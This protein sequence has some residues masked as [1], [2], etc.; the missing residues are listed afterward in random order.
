MGERLKLFSHNV[1][2]LSINGA[3]SGLCEE[4]KAC[5]V[6]TR[7]PVLAGQ[8]DPL[9]E[10]ASLLTQTPAPST[11]DPAQEDL[12]QKYQEQVERLSQQNR[13]IKICSDAGFPTTGGC[14]T[15]SYGKR[16]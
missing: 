15:V 1:N 6:R 11:D 4:Y 13:V 2:Q 10:Q 3:V 12:L 8:T 5:R 14:R 7:R 9:V 16:H